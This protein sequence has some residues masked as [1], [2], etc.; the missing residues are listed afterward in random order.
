MSWTRKQWFLAT[1]LLFAAHLAAV[2]AL[3]GRRPTLARFELEPLSNGASEHSHEHHTLPAETQ[4]PLIFA[5]AHP[6]GFSGAAWI[7]SP[8]RNFQ[9]G[10]LDIPP[11]FLRFEREPAQFPAQQ[12]TPIRTPLPFIAL[13]LPPE[14]P[15]TS[16]FEIEGQLAPR[17]LLKTPPIPVQ[18][19][20][21][22]LSNTVVQI[23]VQSDGFPYTARVVRGSGLRK[24]D[25][26]ALEIARNLRFAPRVIAA[27]YQEP[28][29]L[30]W[31]QVVF[32]WHSTAP[33]TN[34]PAAPPLQ[35]Q[36]GK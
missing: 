27:Q 10:R 8:A 23:A 26:D 17:P 15:R 31:G 9:I 25:A 29:P 7:K 6:R 33:S 16:T 32:H 12:Q 21:D 36:T 20:T 13:N 28:P 34:K 14:P 35:A 22:V 24:A 4:D 2:F 3:H 1:L 5:S 18:L 11:Q 30:E 19:H